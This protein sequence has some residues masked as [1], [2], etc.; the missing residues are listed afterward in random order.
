MSNL[1]SWSNGAH[2]RV[3]PR[4][5]TQDRQFVITKPHR[6]RLTLASRR[7]A[8][9]TCAHTT[10]LP[11]EREMSYATLPLP[12]VPGRLIVP[13]TGCRAHAT[14]TKFGNRNSKHIAFGVGAKRL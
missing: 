14:S 4:R 1:Q 13:R 7:H 2:P 12:P 9:R 8:R 11:P 6:T 5:R 10:N 3:W